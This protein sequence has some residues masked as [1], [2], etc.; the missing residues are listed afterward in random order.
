VEAAG[1]VEGPSQ[2]GLAQAA[3]LSSVVQAVDQAVDC[4][5]PDALDDVGAKELCV[6]QVLNEVIGVPRDPAGD[7]LLEVGLL[8][9]AGRAHRLRRW[10]RR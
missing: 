7:G 4:F 6:T 2:L 10:R 8:P 5:D 3:R 1:A 9:D